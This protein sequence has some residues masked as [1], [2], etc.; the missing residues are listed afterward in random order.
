MRN[1]GPFAVAVGAYGGSS[2]GDKTYHSRRMDT[3]V[4]IVAVQIAI[5]F[6]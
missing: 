4:A 1:R 2:T 5:E 3:L 6:G